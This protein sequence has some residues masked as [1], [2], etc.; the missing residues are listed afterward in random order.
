MGEESVYAYTHVGTPYYM[1]PEQISD[2]KYNEKSDI[3]SAGCVIYEFASLRAPFEA[4]NQIQLAMKIKAGKIE[5]IPSQYSDELF[6]VIQAMMSQEQASRPTVEDLMQHSRI[7][8]VL[9]DIQYKDYAQ[10][11]KRKEADF[12]K[13]EAELKEREDA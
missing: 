13:K 7:A 8:K 3:W 11:I 9:R 1:S 2:Q 10:M 12:S 5:R 6:Q 4:T